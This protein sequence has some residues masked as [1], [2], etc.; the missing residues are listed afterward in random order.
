MAWKKLSSDTTSKHKNVFVKEYLVNKLGY[1]YGDFALAI[2][3]LGIAAVATFFVGYIGP[4]VAGILNL[5]GVGLSLKALLDLFNA[6]PEEQR[7]K[8]VITDM[9]K[10]GGNY[11]QTVTELWQWE[12][13]NG[14]SY[15][16]ETRINYYWY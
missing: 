13:A 12:S 1:N 11:I 6:N 9:E 16:W 8:Q 7:L 14:N 3:G 2:A 15:T 10:Y 5:A 4:I